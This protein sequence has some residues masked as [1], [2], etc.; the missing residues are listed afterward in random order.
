[1]WRHGLADL[2][3]IDPQKE[4]I[5]RNT[6]QF[7]QGKPANN[8]LLTGARGTGKSSLIKALPECLCGAGPAPDRGGQGRP[9]GP[10]RHRRRGV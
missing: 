1:M 8:V 7:V 2:K 9:D 10:A 6:L 5:E 4:K 3:E